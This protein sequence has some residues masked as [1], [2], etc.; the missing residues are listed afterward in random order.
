MD[1]AVLKSARELAAD[2][3]IRFPNE[4]DAYRKA[5]LDLLAEEIELRRHIERVAKLRRA[6]PQGGEVTGKFS[7][8]GADGPVAFEDLFRGKSTLIAYSYMYGPQ[9]ARPCPMCTAMLSSLDG[10]ARD[11]EQHVALAIIARSPSSRLEEFKRERGWRALKLYADES[12]DYTRAYVHPEDLD[13][14]A[15]NVFTRRDGVVRH[16]WSEEMGPW[17]E[18]PGGSGRGASEIMPLWSFL[19]LTPGG[20]PGGW[21]PKLN[22]DES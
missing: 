3:P 4:S 1:Q 13:V 11:L 16:F 22:Y 2:D 10:E 5:R 17:A 7:F 15:L 21:F 14:P 8:V 18:D 19:D 12:G 9:R 6:L 20:R